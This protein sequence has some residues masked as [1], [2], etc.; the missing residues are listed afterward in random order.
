M[1]PSSVPTYRRAWRLFCQFLHSTFPG[2]QA[3][4]PIS[5]PTLAL[6]IAYLFDRNYAPSTVNTYVSAIGYFH[7]LQGFSDPTKI[8][9]ILQMLR[10]YGKI[11]MRL[12]SRLPITMPILHKIVSSAAQLSDT[13]YITCQFQAM[14]LFAFNAFARV[15]EITFSPSGNIIHLRQL[16]KLLNDNKEVHALKI[17]FLNYKH[18]YNNGQ[19]C[20]VISRQ[21]TCCP[22]LFMLEYLR[23]RGSKPGPLFQ[24]QEGLPVSRS[25]FTSR[26]SAVIK[27]CGLDPSRYKGHSF[28]IGAAS[29]AADK[30][31][32]DSQ[33]RTLGRWK[34][35]AFLKYIRVQSLAS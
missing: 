6:F 15:G 22:V 7:K 31:M 24:S 25:E 10:G 18:C 30:G 5:A 35:N 13:Y 1:Q 12:D 21:S 19:F 16:S 29:H 23:L 11:G 32:S 27:L 17:T 33:I 34:S 20:L 3:S 4:L 14:C 9:F 26:L 28:R 8:F 2:V